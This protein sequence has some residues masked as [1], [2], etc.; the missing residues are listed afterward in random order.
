MIV[1]E[2]ARLPDSLCKSFLEDVF[3]E[4]K[5]SLPWILGSS[6]VQKVTEALTGA[7]YT[8]ALTEEV[9]GLQ[10]TRDER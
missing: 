7:T 3:S 1:R 9:V 10:M 2:M 5:L 6:E 8:P 4:T